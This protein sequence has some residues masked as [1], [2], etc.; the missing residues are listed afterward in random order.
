[1]A[2]DS[3]SSFVFV[4]GA[5]GTHR[6]WR[7]QT[8]AFPNSL[9]IDL[10]GH[11]I[12]KGCKTISDYAN[13]VAGTIVER[14]LATAVLVGHSMGGATAIEI[15]LS[16]PELLSGIVLVGSGA[17]LR[18]APA[19]KDE[20]ACD[21]A[22]AAEMIVDWACSPKTDV[23]L[24]RASVQELL[25]VSADVTL[26]DFEACDHFD[27]MSDIDRITLPTLIVCGQ[28]DRLTPVKYSLY[29]KERIPRARLVVIPDAGHSVMLEK[30]QEL[31]AE[32]NSFL[33]QLR[34]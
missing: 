4:H 32:L 9:A 22:H 12:G 14:S 30:P 28:D 7:H 10:P 27:R 33:S 13:Y 17:R 21:Y 24:R 31:N 16:R 1:L 19:I 34:R 15:A 8:A 25:Q 20:I 26:G 2:T 6:V 29:M 23:K 18:V 11:P 3:G 5:G